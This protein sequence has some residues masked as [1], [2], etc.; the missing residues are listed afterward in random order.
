MEAA[1]DPWFA[2]NSRF[3]TSSSATTTPRALRRILLEVQA[4]LQI[5]EA[6][7]P[8]LLAQETVVVAVDGTQRQLPDRRARLVT[9]GVETPDQ[10]VPPAREAQGGERH[11]HLDHVPV[12]ADRPLRR[13]DRVP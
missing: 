12:D 5:A 8:R 3:V 6:G 11:G 13:P 2:G 7:E 1:C 4:G 10:I 9:H